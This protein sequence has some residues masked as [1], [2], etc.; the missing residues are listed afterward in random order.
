MFTNETEDSM[1][2]K[3]TQRAVP[4]NPTVAAITCRPYTSS[5]AVLVSDGIMRNFSSQGSYIETT[6]QFKSGTILILQ[7][8][9]YP[10]MPA[11]ITHDARP[12]S[13]CLAEVKWQQE[14]IDENAIR[15]GIGLKYLR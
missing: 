1:S 5:G 15:Y 4:R 11:S 12:R 7:M 9:R 6:H 8:V 3:R 13:I 2:R 14:L 10:S